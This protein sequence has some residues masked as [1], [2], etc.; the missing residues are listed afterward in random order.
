[1]F[2][3]PQMRSPDRFMSAFLADCQET[4]PNVWAEAGSA[5]ETAQR[6]RLPVSWTLG[7]VILISIVIVG[8][9]A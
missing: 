4:G 3:Y 9:C 6:T 1:M 5:I 2:H 8:F 7:S